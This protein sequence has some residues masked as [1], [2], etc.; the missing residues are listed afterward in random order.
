M[1]RRASFLV[2]EVHSG[3]ENALEFCGRTLVRILHLAL[4]LSAVVSFHSAFS[5]SPPW[6]HPLHNVRAVRVA[7]LK[8]QAEADRIMDAL[9]KLPSV[10]SVSDLTP[11]SGFVRVGW[12]VRAVNE[13]ALAQTIMDQG[14]Y[15][16]TTHFTVS[17]Y[18]A[19]AAEVGAIM[20]STRGKYP[21]TIER[22]DSAKG[23]FVLTYLPIKVDPQNPRKVGFAGGYLHHPLSVDKPPKGLGL[24]FTDISAPK[25]LRYP[26]QRALM[27][28]R[29]KLRLVEDFSKPV[30][31]ATR[32]S[33]DPEIWSEGWRVNMGRWTQTDGGIRGI[34]PPDLKSQA[35]TLSLPVPLK[36]AVVQVEVRLD[37]P[38]AERVDAVCSGLPRSSLLCLCHASS[39][40]AACLL[41]LLV[42]LL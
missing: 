33:L 19:H 13:H 34:V 36:N 4:L 9:R 18:A 24:T 35:A 6:P 1:L 17:D 42:L 41:Q 10:W 14:S 29:G 22:V 21:V 3:D 26:M 8:S 23:E 20:D 25:G 15:T 27:T 32:T 7:G 2:Q 40:R 31:F 12:D 39:S 28:F 16:V 38:L 37:E 11:E 30:N 5:A